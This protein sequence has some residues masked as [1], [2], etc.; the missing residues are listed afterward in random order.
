[1]ADQRVEMPARQKQEGSLAFDAG[2]I[3]LACAIIASLFQR[4]APDAYMVRSESCDLALLITF[5]L[6]PALP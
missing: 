2:V 5:S 4:N 1:M 6:H 3:F